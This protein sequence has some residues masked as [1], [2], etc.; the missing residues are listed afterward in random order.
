MQRIDKEQRA[1]RRRSTTSTGRRPGAP[2]AAAAAAA[3]AAR[4]HDRLRPASAVFRCAT[5]RRDL[6]TS[7][8]SAAVAPMI[9]MKRLPILRARPADCSRSRP[10]REAERCGPRSCS[11]S[12]ALQSP[13]ALQAAVPL[14]S[15]ARPPTHQPTSARSGAALTCLRGSVAHHKLAAG[16]V[17]ALLARGSGHQQLAARPSEGLDRRLALLGGQAVGAAAATGAAVAHEG[18]HLAGGRAGGQGGRLRQ[19]GVGWAAPCQ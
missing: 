2:A 12:H 3:A 4:A 13:R 11:A 14:R 8:S 15:T 1:A 9:S 17:D 6:D 19:A 7:A 5:S 18:V 16:H 10:A